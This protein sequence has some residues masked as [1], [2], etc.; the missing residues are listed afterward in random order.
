MAQWQNVLS[1]S[2]LKPGQVKELSWQG[3]DILLFRTHAGLCLAI[4]AYCP[5]QGNYMPNGLPPGATLDKLLVQDELNCPYHGWRFNGAGQCTYI[6]QGQRVPNPIR[7]GKP[8]IRSWPVR[9]DKNH[10]QLH[11]MP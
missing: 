10:I 2:D 1:S 11:A 3:N 4:N 9:E 8:V 7:Q 6:P 5:H